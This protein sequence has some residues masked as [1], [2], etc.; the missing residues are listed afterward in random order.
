[1]TTTD[2]TAMRRWRRWLLPAVMSLWCS[3]ALGEGGIPDTLR[4]P[5]EQSQLY[6][7]WRNLSNESVMFP[8]DMGDLP[9]KLTRQRQLFLDNYLIADAENVTREVHQP[10][11]HA[12]NPVFRSQQPGVEFAFPLQVRQFDTAPRFR[13][14][15]WSS[16][17]WHKLA[18]GQ[19]VRFGTSYAVSDDGVHWR[20]PELDVE[21]IEGLATRNVVIPYGLMHGLFYEPD[22]PDPQRRFKA[23]V[24]VEG[25]NP[26]IREGYYLHTSPDGIRWKADLE[27]MIIPSLT[28]YTLPQSGI[29]DTSRFWWDPIHRRYLC[30]AKLVIPPKHRCR[31]MM[32][33]DDLVHWSRAVPTF[34]CR[35]CD[36]GARGGGDQIYGHT[37][38]AYQGMYVGTRWI[39]RPEYDWDTHAMHV[40]LDCSRDGQVWTRVGAGQ[41]FMAVN[42]KRDTW[43]CSRMKPTALLE[44]GDEIWIYYAAAPTAKDLENPNMPPSERRPW[45]TGLATLKRDRF[46]S[47]NAART[48]GKLVT[49]PLTTSGRKLHLNAEVGAGGSIRVAL[50]G[51]NRDPRPGYR[52]EDAVPLVEGGLSVPVAWKDKDQLPPAAEGPQRLA[53]ELNN[54]KLYAFWID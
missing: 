15:Y 49:R 23:L 50:L 2:T 19:E 8:L 1:M 12:D 53:F 28:G 22:E 48:P 37:G 38:F 5:F 46:V 30:D 36:I 20:A 41:P 47:I 51:S 44:V 24:C 27:H 31:A 33:S 10:K 13:M 9:V 42:P 6:T 17:G 35:T 29:G 34:V 54:A 32:T 14:W 40:E 3:S 45:E 25:R 39:Y 18:T 52:L 26:T 7:T 4:E 21:R 16:H 43:D 11:R